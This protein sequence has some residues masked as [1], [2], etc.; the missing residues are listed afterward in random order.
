[1]S[2]KDRWVGRRKQ[3]LNVLIACQRYGPGK[4]SSRLSTEAWLFPTA[5]LTILAEKRGTDPWTGQLA[6][7]GLCR[8]SFFLGAVDLYKSI[9]DYMKGCYVL[10]A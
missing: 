1:V 7:C 10:T 9:D 6:C 8:K 5:S 2:V 3:V 4:P